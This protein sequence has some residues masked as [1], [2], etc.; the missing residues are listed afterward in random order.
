[1]TNIDTNSTEESSGRGKPVADK[2][3]LDAAGNVVDIEKATTLSYKNLATGKVAL[4]KVGEMDPAVQLMLALFGATTLATNTA[5]F[6][7]NAA[8]VEDRFADDADAVTERFARM[9]AGQWGNKGGGGFGIDVALLYDAIA[10][11]KGNPDWH[12]DREA[13]IAQME[14]DATSRKTLRNHSEIA[15]I[16]DRMLRERRAPKEEKSLDDLLKV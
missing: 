12:P 14:E 11:R 1:M 3:F 5:S 13:W 8:K 2:T 16:Y 15:P 10:E 9:E 4:V 7:R 6:N